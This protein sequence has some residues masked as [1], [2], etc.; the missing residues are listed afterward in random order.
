MGAV[1][2]AAARRGRPVRPVSLPG[3]TE[4]ALLAAQ[5]IPTLVLGP[6]GW[7][8]H[9]PAERVVVGDIAL[10]ADLLVE[11]LGELAREEEPRWQM[12]SF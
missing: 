4:A 5:G 11:A 2:A 1:T 10:G 7:G 9:T 3:W 8:A 12:D 6:R